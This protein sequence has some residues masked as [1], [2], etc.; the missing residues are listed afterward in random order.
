MYLKRSV[1]LGIGIDILYEDR[2][3]AHALED[4]LET[5]F[6]FLIKSAGESV[7]RQV[8]NTVLYF[9]QRMIVQGPTRRPEVFG[10]LQRRQEE[11]KRGV[12]LC[13]K[14][15]PHPSDCQG[16]ERYSACLSG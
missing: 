6:E 7:V 10:K 1:G 14:T 11:V 12:E 15:L 16:V 13:K 4:S 5:F 8:P 9:L 2:I 3:G